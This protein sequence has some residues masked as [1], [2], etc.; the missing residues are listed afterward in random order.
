MESYLE[1]LALSYPLRESI[2]HSILERL[3]LPIGSY[4]LDAGCGIGDITLMLARAVGPDGRVKGIDISKEFVEHAKKLSLEAGLSDRVHFEE[5][6]LTS[7]PFNDDSFGWLW[8]MDCA[9]FMPSRG[10]IS[11][12]KLLQELSRVVK[13]GGKLALLVWSSQQLLPGYPHLEARLNTTAMGTAPFQENSDPKTHFLRVLD[14]FEKP[15]LENPSVNTFVKTIHAPISEE[16]KKSVTSLIQMRWN[17]KSSE[18]SQKDYT[19]YQRVCNPDSSDYI[20]NQEGYY[21]FFTYS[22]FQCDVGK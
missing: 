17:P 10:M 14:W 6:N 18:L 8:S 22:L 3:Q 9:A 11:Q 12:E 20:L 4:G 21:A 13:P 16:I 2:I 5:G 15:N 19:S 1:K 7:L